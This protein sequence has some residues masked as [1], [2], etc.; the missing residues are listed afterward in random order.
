MNYR[1]F[2]LI[3]INGELVIRANENEKPKQWIEVKRQ[4]DFNTTKL[5]PKF[6]KWQSSHKEIPF[7][8]KAEEQFTYSYL[9]NNY[10]DKSIQENPIK[11]LETEF[12]DDLKTGIQID[13]VEVKNITDIDKQIINKV[14][15]F[16]PKVEETKEILEKLFAQ[17][18]IIEEKI[19][20]IDK[21]ALINYELKKLQS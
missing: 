14:A 2:E 10:K 16:K 5:N 7:A 20:H 12:R 17:R 4:L 21:M 18:E 13:C 3:Q 15:C 6:V 9:F 8:S 19:L 11:L 1:Y